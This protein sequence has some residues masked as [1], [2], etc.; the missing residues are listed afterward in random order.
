MENKENKLN[1]EPIKSENSHVK[2]NKKSQ[3]GLKIFLIFLSVFLIILFLGYFLFYQF[4][5]G[6]Y[7]YEGIEF[8]TVQEGKL[9]LYKT[10][11]PV[12]YQG[13]DA[14]YN[15]YL[16]TNPRVLN[17]MPF[18]GKENLLLMKNSVI[19]FEDNFSC[20][21]DE[22]IAIANLVQLNQVLNV[23]LIRDDKAGCDL[24]GRYN[25]LNLKQG[26]KTEIVEFGPNCYDIVVSNC[27]ILKAT[28]KYMVEFLIKYYQ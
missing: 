20:D 23:S 25:Y 24:R 16:R 12:V 5:Y 13:K 18:E 6:K 1:Q 19:N 7:N 9:L 2:V 22:V 4:K 15:L 27:E 3:K 17:K 21:G 8:K 14:E 28:E 26:N 10:V 11:L